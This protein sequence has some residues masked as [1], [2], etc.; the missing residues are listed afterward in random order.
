MTD[1][2]SF[3]GR[4][5]FGKDLGGEFGALRDEATALRPV[6]ARCTL[7]LSFATDQA[8]GVAEI[9]RLRCPLVYRRVARFLFQLSYAILFPA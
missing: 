8:A 2:W 1:R 7:R 9:V 3:T 5:V 6:R 4:L